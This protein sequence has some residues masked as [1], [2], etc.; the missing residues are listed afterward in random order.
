MCPASLA[1]CVVASTSHSLPWI[2]FDSKP[3]WLPEYGA[4]ACL[5]RRHRAAERDGLGTYAIMREAG[6]FKTAV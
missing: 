6:V 3:S 5:A 4:E 2:A 1:E